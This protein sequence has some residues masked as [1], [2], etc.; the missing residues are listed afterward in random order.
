MNAS[1]A[2][3]QIANAYASSQADIRIQRGVTSLQ[4]C[5]FSSSILL[6][7][8]FVLGPIYFR[9]T[10]PFQQNKTYVVTLQENTNKNIFCITCCLRM[11]I[12]HIF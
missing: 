10:S 9:P 4:I 8:A 12:S 1:I 2:L 5:L 7:R 3:K 6:R 11:L